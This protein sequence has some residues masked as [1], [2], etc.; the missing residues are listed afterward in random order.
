MLVAMDEQI[1]IVV[2]SWNLQSKHYVETL[3]A[4]HWKILL[5]MEKD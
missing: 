4:E 3:S 1:I 2:G 5:I